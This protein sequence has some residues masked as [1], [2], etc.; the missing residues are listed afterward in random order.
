MNNIED[1]LI[2]SFDSNPSEDKTVMVVVRNDGG[3]I[4]FINTFVDDE[5]KSIYTKLIEEKEQAIV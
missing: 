5:A 4:K 2:V 1:S 3:R